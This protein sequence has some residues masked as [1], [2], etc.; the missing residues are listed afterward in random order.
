MANWKTEDSGLNGSI[1]SLSSNCLQWNSISKIWAYSYYVYIFLHFHQTL[2][3][4]AGMSE[5]DTCH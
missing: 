5:F 2:S 4:R 1:H 3:F